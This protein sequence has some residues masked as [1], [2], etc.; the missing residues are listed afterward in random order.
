LKILFSILRKLYVV[1]F[2]LL[3]LPVGWGSG[4]HMAKLTGNNKW[5]YALGFSLGVIFLALPFIT[6]RVRK[7]LEKPNSSIK[8]D[9]PQAVRPLP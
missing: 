4:V 6:N 3:L 2:A 7:M 9:A 5:G 8:R 1:I